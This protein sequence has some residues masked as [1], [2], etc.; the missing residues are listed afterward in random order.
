MTLP[1]CAVPSGAVAI[2]S[3]A[4]P[5]GQDQTIQISLAGPTL[6]EMIDAAGIRPPVQPYLRVWI[7]KPGSPADGWSIP[8]ANWSR[9]RP[10]PGHV[11]DMRIVPAGG[12]GGGKKNP[13]RTVLSIAVVA[14]SFYFGPALAASS[15]GQGLTASI[16]GTGVSQTLAASLTRGIMGMAIS[17]VGNMLVDAIAPPASPEAPSFSTSSSSGTASVSQTITGIQNRINRYGPIPEIFGRNLV[18]PVHFSIPVSE[19]EGSDRYHRYLFVYGYGPMKL[20]AHRI[21]LIDLDRFE[22][23]EIEIREGWEDDEPITLYA[24]TP[25][26]DAYSMRLETD[27]RVILETRTDTDE[28]IAD[29][30][31]LNGLVSFTN[32]GSRSNRTVEVL[33]EYREKGTE[34]WLVPNGDTEIEAATDIQAH[35]KV[36]E[37]YDQQVSDGDGGYTTVTQTRTLTPNRF[38]SQTTDFRAKG[39]QSGDQI[40]VSGFAD[41]ANNGA[42]TVTVVSSSE[43]QVSQALADE[44]AGPAID[45]STDRSGLQTITAKTEQAYT[46]AVRITP[47]PPGHLGD[48]L[49]QPDKHFHLPAGAEHPDRHHRPFG[50]I[51]KPRRSPG[52]GP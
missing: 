40:T 8:R 49:H 47:R 39:I 6:Q 36:T 29:I 9:I 26:E 48:Q 24:D 2:R 27:E 25:R 5:L 13:L 34:E 19:N 4:K 30:T 7:S 10:K 31:F 22:D 32:S 23:V 45:I 38:T 17:F 52:P 11:I 16:V 51:C 15:F 1:I 43:I 35:A 20:S 46:H 14:A 3:S 21:G 41:E 33:V 37:T 42:M 44:A 28:I 18:H 50:Q 12:G